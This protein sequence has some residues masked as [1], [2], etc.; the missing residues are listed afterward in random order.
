MA[1]LVRGELSAARLTEGLC[2]EQYEF[3]ENLAEIDTFL[4]DNPSGPFVGAGHCAGLSKPQLVEKASQSFAAAA[5]KEWQKIH[6][7]L[8]TCERKRVRCSRPQP[9]QKSGIATF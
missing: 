5:A 8:Q 4:C 2:A 1:P 3:A 6:L 9:F 7:G